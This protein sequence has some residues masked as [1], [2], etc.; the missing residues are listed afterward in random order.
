MLGNAQSL[1]LTRGHHIHTLKP[2]VLSTIHFVCSD[3]GWPVWWLFTTEAVWGNAFEENGSGRGGHH[4]GTSVS[5]LQW[6]GRSLFESHHQAAVL[7]LHS[8]WALSS[9]SLQVEIVKSPAHE[10]KPVTSGYSSNLEG[11]IIPWCESGF[12][13]LGKPCMRCQRVDWLGN[14]KE[15]LESWKGHHLNTRRWEGWTVQWSTW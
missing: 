8:Q 12:R 9:S 3:D 11:H 13:V 2:L 15:D 7:F 14:Q 5:L 6:S 4:V 1:T 10:V